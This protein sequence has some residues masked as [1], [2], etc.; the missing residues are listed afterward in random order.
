[1]KHLALSIRQPWAWLIVNGYKTVENRTWNTHFRGEFYIHTGQ[2]WGHEERHAVRVIQEETD[3]KLPS[4]YDLGGIVGK[5]YLYDVK[6]ALPKNMSFWFTGP[7]GFFLRDV[8]EI[9]FIRCKGDQKFFDVT[10]IIE[11]A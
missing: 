7:K 5:A 8:E 10:K 4:T 9:P 2:T 11:A 1:M 6:E 3:I